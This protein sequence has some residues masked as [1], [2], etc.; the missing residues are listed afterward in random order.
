MS[1]LEVSVLHHNGTLIIRI[2]QRIR[3][4]DS[5]FHDLHMIGVDLLIRRENEHLAMKFAEEMG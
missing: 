3:S 4:G 5:L 2:L 1:H